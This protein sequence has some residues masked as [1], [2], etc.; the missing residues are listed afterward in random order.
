MKILLKLLDIIKYIIILF[1]CIVLLVSCIGAGI[2]MADKYK[3]QEYPF[4]DVAEVQSINYPPVSTKSTTTEIDSETNQTGINSITTWGVPNRV[5]PTETLYFETTINNNTIQQRVIFLLNQNLD[6][7]KDYNITFSYIGTPARATSLQTYFN[8]ELI[9]NEINQGSIIK[10]GNGISENTITCQIKNETNQIHFQWILTGLQGYHIE[11]GKY[12]INILNF[13]V[14]DINNNVIASYQSYLYDYL[15]N[16]FTNASNNSYDEGYNQGLNDTRAN[17]FSSSTKISAYVEED[18]HILTSPVEILPNGIG[19]SEIASEADTYMTKNEISDL[20]FT[21][22][23]QFEPFLFENNQI[24]ISIAY[25]FRT[26]TLYDTD[27]NEYYM[28]WGDV[29]TDDGYAIFEANGNTIIGKTITKAKIGFQSPEYVGD[30]LTP[31]YLSYED[32]YDNGYNEGY[33]NGYNIG[34]GQTIGSLTGWDAVKNGITSIFEAL[35]IKVFGLFSLG[36]VIMICLVF[37][38]VMFFLKVI[39]G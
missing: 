20:K 13:K 11:P 36:D 4:E 8:V 26:L 35:Q 3:N 6:I 28:S 21:V 7:N 10:N 39:R 17:V 1:V 12:W 15:K 24:Y 37:A 34:V 19:F 23:F 18:N 32:Y 30:L 22:S 5:E 33:K 14:E 27:E 29:K 38:V 9:L 16:Q 25:G 31:D 2:I